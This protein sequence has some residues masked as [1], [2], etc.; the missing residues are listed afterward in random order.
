[1]NILIFYDGNEAQSL[2]AAAILKTKYR[3]ET[4]TATDLQGKN[5]GAM[6]TAISTGATMNRVFNCCISTASYSA[7]GHPSRD[8]NVPLMTARLLAGNVTPWDATIALGDIANSKNPILLAWQ[9]AYPTV[10]YPP[11]VKYLGGSTTFPVVSG[12]ATSVAAGTLT[13]TSNFTANALI[14]YY[15]YIV[16]SS[17]NPSVGAGQIMLIA[18]NTANVLTLTANWPI[19][20]T[21]TVVYGVVAYKDEALRYECLLLAVKSKLWNLSDPATMNYWYR[22]LDLGSYDSSYNSINTGNLVGTYT[23]AE[24]LEALVESGRQIFEYNA[25]PDYGAVGIKLLT[26]K[27]V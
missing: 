21:G 1:M 8:V 13:H 27:K 3:S 17:S 7:V 6:T 19:T 9:N 24:L 16:S 5:E 14:G 15:V 25:F 11:I 10:A 23:D 22:L 20:P 18:S 12:T 2:A 26:K 4:V